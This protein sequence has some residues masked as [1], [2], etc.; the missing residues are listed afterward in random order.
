[1]NTDVLIVGGSCGGLDTAI[2]LQHQARDVAITLVN[3]APYLLY[4]PWLIS[5]PAQRRSFQVLQISLHKAAAY[6]LRLITDTVAHLDL[7]Q[8]QA[9]LG[10][11]EPFDL[12]LY[13]SGAWTLVVAAAKLGCSALSENTH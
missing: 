10:T 2:Q 13:R 8:H 7:E 6:Q 4:C 3:P 12:S 11:G 1:M 5:L 9:W